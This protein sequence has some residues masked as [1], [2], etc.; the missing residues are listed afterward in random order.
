[1]DTNINFTRFGDPAIFALDLRVALDPDPA[2]APAGAVGS[3][4]DWRLWINGANLCNYKLSSDDSSDFVSWYLAPLLKWIA[5]NWAPLLHEMRLP[6]IGRDISESRR[7]LTARD[8]F[9]GAWQK[10]GDEPERFSV[11]QEWAARHSLRWAAEGGIFPDL[12]IRRVNDEMEFSWGH[13]DQPGAEFIIFAL[14]PGCAQLPAALVARVLDQSLAWSLQQKELRSQP[15]FEEYQ[16]LVSDRIKFGR[17]KS[18]LSWFVGGSEDES[19]MSQGMR[20]I[21]DRL[22]AASEKLIGRDSPQLCLHPLAPEVVMFGALSPRISEDAAFRL[23]SIVAEARTNNQHHHLVDKF[24]ENLPAIEDRSPWDRGYELA[25]LS[26]EDFGIERGQAPLDLDQLLRKLGVT[27][28]L[29]PLGRH[30]PRGAAIAGNELRPTVIINTDHP[31]NRLPKGQRFTI[32]HELCHILFDQGRAKWISHASTPWAPGAVEQRAN[33]FAAMLLM[34]LDAVRP[35][36]DP[37]NDDIELREV[38]DAAE[39][40]DV[41]IRALVNHLGNLGEITPENRDR[42]LEDLD[43]QSETKIY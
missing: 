33:A 26:R 36:F 15:W 25:L 23:L 6:T 31:R 14:D 30:G 12:F 24:V 42:L 4:G 7:A 43:E 3:W 27:K 38:L 34:P 22:V 32:A 29:E 17:T 1:M 41:S 21:R 20:A 18:W 10:T 37:F 11:W 39:R 19:P 5:R 13:R 2:S 9:L 16:T 28:L 35:R 40:L 8:A